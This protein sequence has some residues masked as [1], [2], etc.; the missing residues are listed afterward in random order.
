MMPESIRI[1]F[2]YTCQLE[3]LL[4]GGI[5]PCFRCLGA[6]MFGEQ[7]IPHRRMAL[8]HQSVNNG[9]LLFGEHWLWALAAP[10]VVGLGHGSCRSKRRPRPFPK[11]IHG[12]HEPVM[13]SR[14]AYEARQASHVRDQHTR[15]PTLVKPEQTDDTIVPGKNTGRH[16]V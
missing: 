2:A 9:P 14:C 7:S 3:V 1:R 12:F 6:F 13:L 8:L 10:A 15:E 4:T 16:V 11:K 5:P